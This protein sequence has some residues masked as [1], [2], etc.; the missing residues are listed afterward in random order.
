MARES[1]SLQEKEEIKTKDSNSLALAR[2]SLSLEENEEIKTND[3]KSHALARASL[4][5]EEREEIKEKNSKSHAL[6]RRSLSLQESGKNKEKY[7]KQR[8]L[9]RKSLPNKKRK[10]EIKYLKKLD[11]SKR[12]NSYKD[13]EEC[14]KDW[15]ASLFEGNNCVCVSC[16]KYVSFSS[17]Q[18]LN[19]E[20]LIKKFPDLKNQS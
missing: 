19:E 18:P 9:I 6:A 12:N 7:T 14:L 13:F 16:T 10:F 3:S 20:K 8:A 15:E 2:E 5:L 11:R 17:T 4:S 1:L